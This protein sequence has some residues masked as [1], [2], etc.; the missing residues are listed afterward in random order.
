MRLRIRY[1]N[2]LAC[3]VLL[4]LRGTTCTMPG[5]ERGC[6]VLPGGVGAAAAYNCR[7]GGRLT[8]TALS[9]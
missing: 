3:C 6:M 5:T 1:A 8:P 9:P 7:E 2:L 4:R